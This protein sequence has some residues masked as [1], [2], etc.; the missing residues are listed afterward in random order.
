M[1][2]E[3][4]CIATKVGSIPQMLDDGTVGLLIEAKKYAMEHY[5]HIR[6]A[7]LYLNTY[8][9]LCSKA[10]SHQSDMCLQLK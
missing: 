6:M 1:Y 9:S 7:N 5:S 4:D 2:A 8:L 10:S 3:M